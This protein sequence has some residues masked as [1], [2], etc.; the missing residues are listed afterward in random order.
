LKIDFPE[1]LDIFSEFFSSITIHDDLPDL[2][3]YK[4]SQLKVFLSSRNILSEYYS[5]KKDEL[6]L[7]RHKV[8]APF[9][10]NFSDVYM[11]VGS[12]TNT[13]G[14]VAHAIQTDMLELEVPVRKD[15]ARWIKLGDEVEVIR[16][17]YND[18]WTGRVS[19]KGMF[20]DEETQRQ[21]VFVRLRSTA[22]KP[23]L[24][25]EYLLARFPGHPEEEVME[26]PRSAVFN[27]NEV[28]VVLDGI[29]E[30]RTIDIVKKDE[31]T[32]IF[33]GLEEGELLVTQALVNVQEGIMVRTSDV[34]ENQAQA[35]QGSS[36]SGKESGA[37][38]IATKS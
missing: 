5:I 21:S 26:I 10:G 30:K 27:S 22:E 15:D 11:Q 32:L 23:M 13:G 9:T 2:P 35:R 6:K 17:G 31:K 14:R 19:R 25:G 12:Y 7:S 38:D 16:E 3:E 36:G 37:G 8:Y 1:H 34:K 18:T 20:I 33:R 29:L 4:D 28:F 24:N